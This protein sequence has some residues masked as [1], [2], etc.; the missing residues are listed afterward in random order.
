MAEGQGGGRVPAQHGLF[1]HDDGGLS[2]QQT[3]SPGRTV[4]AATEGGRARP[5]QSA[6]RSRADSD[7]MLTRGQPLVDVSNT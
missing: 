1:D 5:G 2:L 7:K 3:E 4:A 6:C